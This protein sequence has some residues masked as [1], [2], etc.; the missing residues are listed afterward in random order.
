[1]RFAAKYYRT[2]QLAAVCCVAF[3]SCRLTD[4][5]SQS[6]RT[7]IVLAQEREPIHIAISAPRFAPPLA[8]AVTVS[9]GPQQSDPENGTASYTV[10]TDAT[11]QDAAPQDAVPQNTASA[12]VYVSDANCTRQQAFPWTMA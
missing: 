2:A 12:A 10:V 11:P 7:P 1:M 3:C 6:T 4:P 9:D 5:V 8:S